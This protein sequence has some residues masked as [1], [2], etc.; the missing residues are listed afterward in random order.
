MNTDLPVDDGHDASGTGFSWASACLS[1]LLERH[2]VPS[3][4]QATE[5]AHICAISVSQARRKLRGAVWLFDEVQ[6]ICRHF[7]ESL[8]TVFGA[9]ALQTGSTGSQTVPNPANTYPATL[10][11]DG[12]KMACNIQLGPLCTTA[13]DASCQGLVAFYNQREGWLVSGIHRMQQEGYSGAH[14]AVEQ[15]QVRNPLEQARARIAVLDDDIGSA[16][17][18]TDWFNEVGYE[19]HAYTS[20]AALLARPL[21]EHDAFVVDLILGGG[22]TSQS[23]VERIRLEQPDAPIVLL[24]GQLKDG[25]ASEATLATILRTQ[26]VTFFEKPVRPAVL[27]AAIQSGLDRRSPQHD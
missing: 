10:L 27:T 18:L 20:S 8:D 14:Y 6:T 24:T 17:A 1:A 21:S 12:Q 13:R 9:S 3:R 2:G 11:I 5:I 16:G 26:G 4:H 22:Q 25:T 15:L 19:A 23:I 7:G